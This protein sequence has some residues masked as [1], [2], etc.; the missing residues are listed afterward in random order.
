MG[1]VILESLC[2]ATEDHA[3]AATEA[4]AVDRMPARW[5]ALPD[6]AEQTSAVMRV[7]ADHDLGLGPPEAGPATGGKNQACDPHA[8]ALGVRL[9]RAEI[10][11][12]VN[13][14][15]GACGLANSRYPCLP[16]AEMRRGFRLARPRCGQTP[17]AAQ[18]ERD[19][20]A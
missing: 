10:P 15:S 1:D 16:T 4:D 11:S 2:A 9:S 18:C 12:A 17:G 14:S 6:S 8:R 20:V 19:Q 13:G 3:V 5:V 7:A